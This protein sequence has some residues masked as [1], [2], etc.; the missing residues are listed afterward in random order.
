MR[1]V[2]IGP[3][4]GIH[5]LSEVERSCANQTCHMPGVFSFEVTAAKLSSNGRHVEPGA[6]LRGKNQA[7]GDGPPSARRWRVSCRFC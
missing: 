3:N 4:Q 2:Q 1:S 6:V 7:R 5:S